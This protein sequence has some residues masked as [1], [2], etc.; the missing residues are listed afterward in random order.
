M[1]KSPD[2]RLQ[3]PVENLNPAAIDDRIGILIGSSLDWYSVML[4][5]VGDS[6]YVW[7]KVTRVDNAGAIGVPP[8]CSGASLDDSSKGAALPHNQYRGL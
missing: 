7:Q 8:A 4:G 1:R 6:K 5:C 2:E 3:R